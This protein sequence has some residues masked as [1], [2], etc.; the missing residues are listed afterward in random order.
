MNQSKTYIAIPPGETIREQ[1]QDRGMPQKEFALRMDISEK[2][3]SKL[4]NG[5]VRL[6]PEMARRLEMVLGV[7]ASFWNNLEAI[8]REKLEKVRE[9]N[10]LEEDMEISRLFPYAEMAGFGWI[11]GTRQAKERVV[12][13][14]QFFEVSRLALIEKPGIAPI[15]FRRQSVSEKA[16]YALQAWAQQAKREARKIETAKIDL[17]KLEMLLP[18]FR[19]MT[20]VQPDKFCPVLAEKL[21]SCGIAIVFLPHMKGSFLHGAT[22]YDAKK[23]VIGLTVR[24]KYADKFWFSFFHELAHIF[25]G[26][27]GKPLGPSQED[28]VAADEFARQTLIPDKDFLEFTGRKD[29]SIDAIL[30]FS[31]EQQI[32]PGVLIGRLQQENYIPFSLY[33]KKFRPMYTIK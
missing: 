24:G 22:F 18:E 10:E 31:K 13:L 32:S 11:N 16:V 23:I 17:A 6:T 4:I 3:A 19:K 12:C 9:E 28:E 14:R 20:L 5:E 25:H 8:Y 2:H 33:N 30:A 26:D 1:L 15:A 27:I 7:P 29:F 21:A